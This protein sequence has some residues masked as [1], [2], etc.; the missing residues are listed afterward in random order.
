[1]PPQNETLC[2]TH[3]MG[4]TLPVKFDFTRLDDETSYKKRLYQDLNQD[5]AAAPLAGVCNLLPIV[6]TTFYLH[7]ENTAKDPWQI[8]E[9]MTEE[10]AAINGKTSIQKP[11]SMCRS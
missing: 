1:M 8:Y 9:R 5:T 4:C 7:E 6:E 2:T 11:V 10:T 3:V